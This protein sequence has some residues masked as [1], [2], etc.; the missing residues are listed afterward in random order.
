MP[1]EIN[2]DAELQAA[3]YELDE[4]CE[5][6]D[7]SPENGDQIAELIGAIDAWFEKLR[8][9]KRKIKQELKKQQSTVK[10]VDVEV[11]P[12]EEQK[13]TQKQKS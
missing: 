5:N 12:Q 2:S 3:L 7:E 13:E 6:D 8:Y 10:N 4:V 1:K 9:L 11:M